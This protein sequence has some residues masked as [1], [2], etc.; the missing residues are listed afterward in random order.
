MV[1]TVVVAI[2]AVFAPKLVI[3][4]K[5]GT[6]VGAKRSLTNKIFSFMGCKQANE[7]VMQDCFPPTL[8]TLFKDAWFLW[9]YNMVDPIKRSQYVP[10]IVGECYTKATPT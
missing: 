7:N 4:D 6:L 2:V 5:P 10:P 1:T 8:M 3:K 9:K